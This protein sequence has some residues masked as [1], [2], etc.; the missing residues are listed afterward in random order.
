L[1]AGYKSD[2]LEEIEQQ[3]ERNVNGL[4]Q[5]IQKNAQQNVSALE[6]VNTT[7]G[8]TF[9]SDKFYEMLLRAI[10]KWDDEIAEAF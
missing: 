8:A 2:R 10:G 1:D 3:I 6:N 4:I 9:I 7:D 5:S